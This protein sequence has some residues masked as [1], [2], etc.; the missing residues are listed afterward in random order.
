[1]QNISNIYILQYKYKL[2]NK[3]AGLSRA[4]LKISIRISYEFEFEF[5]DIFQIHIAKLSPSSSSS[6]A[7]LALISISPH[8]PNHPTT[9]ESSEIWPQ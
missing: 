5:D 1:M 7:E 2:Y 9:R 4:T 3:Q 8:P 6:W